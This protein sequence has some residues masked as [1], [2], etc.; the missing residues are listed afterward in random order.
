AAIRSRD[1]DV[2]TT[3]DARL[4]MRVAGALR[5]G[6]VAGRFARGAA[7]V[8]DPATGELLAAASY[9]WPEERMPQKGDATSVEGAAL[10]DRA[11]YGLYPPGST[12]KLLVAGAALRSRHD[13]DRFMCI[14]LPEGRVGN[15]V[16]GSSRPVR[17]DPMDRQPHGAVDLDRGLI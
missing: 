10:L 14:R 8:L 9:P 2:R 5:D 6:I 7:V 4:Q 1:R 12:F 15:Y 16:R 13:G 17:D 3:I 11:R